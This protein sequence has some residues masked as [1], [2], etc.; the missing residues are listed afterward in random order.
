MIDDITVRNIKEAS[1][2]V[3]VVG[4]FIKLRRSG[5]NY[6][7]VCPFHDDHDPSM[8]VNP[9]R[10]IFKCFVCGAG[11]NPVDFLMKHESLSYPDALRYLAQK[12]SIVIDEDY[13]RERFKH[14]KPAKPRDVEDVKPLEM[15]VMDRQHVLETTKERSKNI[16][17]YWMQHL[18]W[19]DEQRE[20]LDKVLWQYCVGHFAKDGRT[21]FWQVD[22]QGRV[23]TGKLMMYGTDGKRNRD[24]WEHPGWA[25]NNMGTFDKEKYG[26]QQCL[27]GLHLIDKYPDVPVN[28]VESEKTAL[29]CATTYGLDKGLWLACG[30][31][32][33]MKESELQ[34][35]I[36]RKRTI[37]L[38]PDKDG[39][40][41]WEVFVDSIAYD[42]I[43]IW[44]KFLTDNWL[45]DDGEKADIADIILRLLRD[46]GTA[47]KQQEQVVEWIDGTPFVDPI[48]LQDPR[49][50]KWRDILSQK[51]NFNKS[52]D[53]EQ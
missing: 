37:Y 11:G 42:N 46:P 18:P 4:D 27:F 44:T 5:V 41:D 51:F 35:L 25:H 34:P 36:D 15:L 32:Q 47:L 49:I 24:K 10:N 6:K 45:S 28:I 52:Q 3:D 39:R 14:I 38:W 16:L 48:E 29:I 9:K 1:S 20:R 22:E 33:N 26:M 43:H 23:H 30:G 17:V 13:D 7:G 21:V 50:A 12:Y 31:L 2:I 40:E 19:N 53:N 8:T